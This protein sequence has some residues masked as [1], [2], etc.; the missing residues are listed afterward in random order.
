MLMPWNRL[1]RSFFQMTHPQIMIGITI[2]LNYLK[3]RLPECERLT[4]HPK[5]GPGSSESGQYRGNVP[6]FLLSFGQ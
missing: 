1:R 2:S 4:C 5:A 6:F 3:A